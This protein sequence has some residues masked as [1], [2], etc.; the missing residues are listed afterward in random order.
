MSKYTQDKNIAYAKELT[1]L[2]MSHGSVLGEPNVHLKK[3]AIYV[4]TN[5]HGFIYS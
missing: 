4:L 5:M 2:R 1:V 3:I